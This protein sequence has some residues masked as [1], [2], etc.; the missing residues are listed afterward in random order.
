MT[1]SRSIVPFVAAVAAATALP[2]VLTPY[3]I[4]VLIQILMF[5]YLSYCWNILGGFAGQLSF[6]HAMF[7]AVGA[8][9]STMLLLKLGL[10][11]WLGMLVGGVLAA[12]IGLF[13]GYVSFR[14]GIKGPYFGLT[15]LAFAE[16]SR[17]VALNIAAI[18]GALGL[19]ITIRS[20]D[21]WQMKFV[22]KGAY[23]YV[24]LGLLIV[25]IGVTRWLELSRTGHCI[26]AVREN[27]QAAQAAGIDVVGYKLVATALSAFLT[28]LGGTFYAH[29]V[30]FIDPHTLLNMNMALEITIYAIVGGLGTLWGPLL[31]AVVLVPLSE[32][33]R[34][35]L[36]HS[37]AGIHLAVYGLALIAIMLFASDGL[38]GLFRTFWRRRAPARVARISPGR[39]AI[40][41]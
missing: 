4:H 35:T 12:L 40:R 20:T 9:T 37:Y 41:P 7:M 26:V 24:I 31:G 22:E 29:Y 13:I 23:Y 14:Y 11:P 5:A 16:I 30:T 39:E 25:A 28:A 18:G 36:G 19:Y 10:T 1:A 21:V 32:V 8:Y 33:M 34:A 15:T 6:G 17:H 27:E 2:F 38:V 3:F